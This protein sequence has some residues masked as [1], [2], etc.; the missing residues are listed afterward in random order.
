MMIVVTLAITMTIDTRDD[1]SGG[2]S[3]ID[4]GCDT[5]G[6]NN[7]VVATNGSDIGSGG[8]GDRGGIS[9]GGGC[10]NVDVLV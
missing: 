5:N 9:G 3:D 10:I 8:G 6:G 1:R 4:C 7:M 2:G